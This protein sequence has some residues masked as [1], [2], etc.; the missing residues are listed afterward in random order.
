VGPATATYVAQRPRTST[1]IKRDPAGP[2]IVASE[3]SPTHAAAAGT[4]RA[5][6]PMSA[7]RRIARGAQQQPR[8]EE[9]QSHDATVSSDVSPS[10][11]PLWWEDDAAR[12]DQ[13]AAGDSA[14]APAGAG[15]ASSAAA[16]AG[17]TDTAATGSSGRSRRGRK[18]SGGNAQ[19]GTKTAG[20]ENGGA[21][22]RVGSVA[23]AGSGRGGE[24]GVV[25]ST[26]V[27]V[28]ASGT[29]APP[30]DDA[31]P[32]AATG[33]RGSRAGPGADEEDEGLQ[34]S[35]PRALR[36][37][38]KRLRRQREADRRASAEAAAAAAAKLS[39]ATRDLDAARADALA[40]RAD[41][42]GARATAKAGPCARA[43]L[44]RN[45]ALTSV[46]VVLC[47]AKGAPRCRRGEGK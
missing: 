9:P 25:D 33:G 38:V 44:V 22:G 46:L 11:G 19:S 41:A 18:A 40:A 10:G 2:L 32:S 1:H 45:C 20:A 3:M 8:P 35:D 12:G 47:F 39:Q 43:L 14:T 16:A 26:V 30:V 21:A 28:V 13:G 7:P 4:P 42:A 6:P 17:M 37:M 24:P 31:R 5:R 27:P 23:A 29:D 36:A 34:G 15:V